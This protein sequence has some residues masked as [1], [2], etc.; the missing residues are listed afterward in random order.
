MNPIITMKY[1]SLDSS[2]FP[3]FK[4]R[5]EVAACFVKWEERLLVLK[6][7]HTEDQPQTWGIPGGKLRQ[8]EK[9]L[10]TIKREIFE[11][12]QLSQPY[13]NLQHCVKLYARIP[14]WDY[15]LDV[16]TFNLYSEVKPDIMLNPKEHDEYL[17]VDGEEFHKLDLLTGQNEVYAYLKAMGFLI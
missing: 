8:N 3:N 9:S 10:D 13:S 7:C 4:P 2:R 15:I 12:T 14:N 16:F 11:E 17:W 1:L 5:A 6:R